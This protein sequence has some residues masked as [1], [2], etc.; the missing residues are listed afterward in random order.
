MRF[1]LKVLL[2]CALALGTASAQRGGGARGGGG[3]S[4]GGGGIGGGFRGGGI[5]GGGFRGGAFGGGFRGGYYG[6]IRGGYYGGFRGLRGYYG[7]YWGLW[8]WPYYGWGFDLGYWP[9]SYYDPYGYYPYSSYPYAG[10]GPGSY[11]SYQASP[12]VTVIYPR[13][14][15][16]AAPAGTQNIREYDEY[17]QEI[18]PP[19]VSAQQQGAPIYLIAF[20]DHVIRAAAAYWVDGQTLHYVTL[21]HEQRQV[22]LSAVDRA[23]SLELNRERRVP[24]QLPAQ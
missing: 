22:P 6:G 4:R 15:Y 8:G 9:P 14:T 20:N 10:Y 7:G 1:S 19:T 21:E 18:R 13:E 11:A 23:F 12:N 24:F 3:G 17:G 2:C 16:A 5:S